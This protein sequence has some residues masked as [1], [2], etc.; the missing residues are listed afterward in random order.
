M[1]R[2]LTIL[3]TFLSLLSAAAQERD[4]RVFHS[5]ED[6]RIFGDYCEKFAGRD[7]L[8]MS[9]LVAETGRYFLGTPYVN[10]TLEVREPE[11]L[12]VNFRELD[13][14]TYVETVIALAQCVKAGSLDFDTY[15]TN[16]RNLR[17]RGG[18]LE[19]FTSRL[20]YFSDWIV[21]NQAMGLM[22]DRTARFGGR[23][24]PISVDLMSTKPQNY[25]QLRANPHMIPV[26]KKLEEQVISGRVMAYIPRGEADSAGKRMHSG[27]VIG[28]TTGQKMDI[29]H[30][31]FLIVE[32]GKPYFMH[33]STL[34]KQVIVTDITLQE[35]LESKRTMN[36]FMA[37]EVLEPGK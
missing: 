36:G 24:Y 31:G 2:L 37:V 7:T 25:R 3:L 6:M 19:D 11:E 1:K 14:V 23:P 33:A 12:I 30:C 8:P 32:G 5:P 16:L 17:Y 18:V 26:L 29:T 28:T 22:E 35:Y 27:L 13:C 34:D 10:F 20:H 9:E 4:Y 15:C 21:D